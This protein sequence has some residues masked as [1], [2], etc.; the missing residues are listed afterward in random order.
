METTTPNVS[1]VN[2]HQVRPADVSVKARNAFAWLEVGPVVIW[3]QADGDG[4][5]SELRAIAAI[6][7]AIEAAAERELGHR[8]QA[9]EAEAEHLV[10]QGG[11]VPPALQALRDRNRR[12]L[13]EEPS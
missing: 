13:A 5:A 10:G 2:L 6:G 1:S 3:P 9:L 4:P 12:M 7:R 11:A 8:R